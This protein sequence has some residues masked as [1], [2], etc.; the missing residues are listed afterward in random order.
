[1]IFSGIP[2]TFNQGDL[3]Q[4][5]TSHVNTKNKVPYEIQTKFARDSAWKYN[6]LGLSAQPSQ[7]RVVVKTTGIAT[8]GT[9]LASRI[10][11]VKSNSKTVYTFRH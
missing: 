1:M 7:K 8:R 4:K 5:Y 11:A 10:R 9:T 2:V 3:S 6:T